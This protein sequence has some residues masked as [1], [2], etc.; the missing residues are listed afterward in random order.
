MDMLV[1]YFVIFS[2]RFGAH[3]GSHK[4]L[5][6]CEQDRAKV[7]AI[8]VKNAKERGD[9]YFISPSCVKVTVKGHGADPI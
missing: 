2:L 8:L 6:A 4:T 5:D 9:S 3:V 7:E 1:F